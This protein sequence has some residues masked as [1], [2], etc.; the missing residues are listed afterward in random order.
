[1]TETY[2]LGCPI[3]STCAIRQINPD[4]VCAERY[5]LAINHAYS[6]GRLEAAKE[7]LEIYMKVANAP[8]VTEGTVDE[9]AAK[10]EEDCD[11]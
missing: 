8:P 2:C 11:E 3:Y 4:K 9:I 5:R 1:M 10:Y 6:T 7:S